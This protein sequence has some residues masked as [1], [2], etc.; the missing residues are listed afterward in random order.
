MDTDKF[1]K[2]NT[3]WLN[4][5]LEKNKWMF[6]IIT[7]FFALQTFLYSTNLQLQT[8]ITIEQISALK[9]I[10]WILIFIIIFLLYVKTETDYK[11]KEDQYM[12]SIFSG[13]ILSKYFM[14]S[15]ILILFSI[16]FVIFGRQLEISFRNSYFQIF[17]L[18]LLVMIIFEIA[19]FLKQKLSKSNKK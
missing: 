15:I 13:A 18:G 4:D 2:N 16:S 19:R 8:D 12:A 3:I 14:R 1:F 10:F 6:E 11:V 9:I 5:Y 7:F 17:W